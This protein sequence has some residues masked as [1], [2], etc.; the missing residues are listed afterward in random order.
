LV[1]EFVARPPRLFHGFCFGGGRLITT[2]EIYG[3]NPW[4][5]GESA[6]RKMPWR[7]RAHQ[8]VNERARHNSAR[9]TMRSH[10]SI[11]RVGE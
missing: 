8:A 6:A 10:P 9:L 4:I 2:G 7:F 1:T 11:G 5:S 3:R